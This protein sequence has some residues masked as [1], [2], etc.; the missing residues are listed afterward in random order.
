LTALSAAQADY[1]ELPNVVIDSPEMKTAQIARRGDGL[2]WDLDAIT[3]RVR[4][5]DLIVRSMSVRYENGNVDQVS[6]VA[7]RRFPNGPQAYGPFNIIKSGKSG[8]CVA[9][10]TL[11]GDDVDGDRT[12]G[13][14]RRPSPS[15]SVVD[16]EAFGRL[17]ARAERPPVVRP[18]PPVVILPPPPPPAPVY[19]TRSGTVLDRDSQELIANPAILSSFNQDYTV[20]LSNPERVG[21]LQLEAKYDDAFIDEV[22]VTFANGEAQKIELGSFT[23]DGWTLRDGAIYL[24]RNQRSGVLDLMGFG[25]RRVTSITVRGREGAAGEANS[26]G[27]K[28]VIEVYGIGFRTE[29]YTVCVAYCN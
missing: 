26:S 7:G 16:F 23:S 29:N 8:W 17:I 21:A 20:T 24:G 22:I 27:L 15:Y 11:V 4:N 25:E 14:P 2:C 5:R 3:F 10:V 18:E 1:L 12:P 19:E 6:G 13:R 9:S 28:P